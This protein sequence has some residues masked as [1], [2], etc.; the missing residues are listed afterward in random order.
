[1]KK[2]NLLFERLPF[3][4]MG[5]LPFLLTFLFFA[6]MQVDMKAQTTTLPSPGQIQPPARVMYQIPSGTFV[7]VAVAKDRLLTAMTNLKHQLG[8]YA[9]GTAPW[10]AAYLRYTYYSYI[11]GYLEQGKSVPESITLGIGNINSDLALGVTPEQSVA[12][13]NAAIALLRP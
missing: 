7:S 10:D 12:E 3:S 9:E 13:K 11:Y 1:M 8:Q 2:S 4:K 5:F 6:A